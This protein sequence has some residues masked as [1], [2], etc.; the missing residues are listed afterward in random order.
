MVTLTVLLVPFRL[1]MVRDS[2]TDSSAEKIQVDH[3]GRRA[4]NFSCLCTDNPMPLATAQKFFKASAANYMES[5]F[6]TI[7]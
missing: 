6:S 3:G 2:V 1:R 4:H 7:P 5:E